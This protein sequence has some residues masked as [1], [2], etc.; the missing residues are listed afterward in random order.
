MSI[1]RGDYL[2]FSD[3]TCIIREQPDVPLCSSHVSYSKCI[4]SAVVEN[5]CDIEV[6]FDASPRAGTEANF[7]TRKLFIL[8]TSC[9]SISRIAKQFISPRQVA[10]YKTFTRPVA[11]VL[12][13]AT[14]TYQL[15]YWT[16]VKLE[17]DE[18]KREKN[19]E[20][21]VPGLNSDRR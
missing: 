13:L 8:C 16:W 5:F 11:K 12:L 17:K 18:I 10:F 20:L 19:C 3:I 1:S 9:Y 14:F 21:S 6:E 15:A 7:S 4:P 2:S